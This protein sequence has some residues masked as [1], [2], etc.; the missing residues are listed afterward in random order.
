MDLKSRQAMD[1]LYSALADKYGDS[2]EALKYRKLDHQSKRFSLMAAIEPIGRETSVL[3][4]GCGLG[5]FCDFLRKYGWQGKY[6]GIDVSKGMVETAAKRLSKDSFICC[7]ILN[8]DFNQEHDYVFCGATIQ[9]KPA[10]VEP[11]QYLEQMVKKMF[12]LA[13]KGLAFDIFSDRV[14]YRDEDKLYVDPNHLLNFCYGLTGRVTLRNDARPY[15]VMA[16]LYKEQNKDEFNVYT[17]WKISEP[18]II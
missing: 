17:D 16:Y 15:E 8:D 5:H 14:D 10:Y 1:G 18:R 7:D 9:I 6:T 11:S 3:D 2:L 12:T 13:K 4:V